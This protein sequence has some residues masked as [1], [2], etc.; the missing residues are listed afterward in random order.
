MREYA[1]HLESAIDIYILYICVGIYNN[2][3]SVCVCDLPRTTHL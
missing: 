3:M 1:Y 2:K